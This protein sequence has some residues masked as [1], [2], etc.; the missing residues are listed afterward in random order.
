MMQRR[1]IALVA[2]IGVVAACGSGAVPV[3]PVTT[4]A[5]IADGAET[6]VLSETTDT[7][8]PATTMATTSTTLATTTTVQPAATQATTTTTV[9]VAATTAPPNGQP[10]PGCVDGWVTP[11]PGT[12]LRTDPLDIIRERM[13][14]TGE[15]L[16][17]EMRYFTGPPPPGLV[18]TEVFERW[19]VKAQLV[20]DPTFK[21]RFVVHRFSPGDGNRRRRP[22]RYHGLAVARLAQL[23]GCGLGI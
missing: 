10:G 3:G 12:A 7:A 1:L 16:V 22:V 9:A 18:S 20:D 8:I 2:L 17:V 21:G 23:R 11:T 4:A 14:I 6:T 5:P 13:G 19:Y 15:F